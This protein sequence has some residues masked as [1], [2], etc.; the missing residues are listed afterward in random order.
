[1]IILLSFLIFTVD[2]WDGG[3]KYDNEPVIYHGIRGKTLT[4]KIFFKDVVKDAILPYAFCKSEFP[5]ILS[6]ENHC[7]VEY[8]DQ[9]ADCLV[10]LL[11]DILYTEKVDETRCEL[12][13][14]DELRGKILVKAKKRRTHEQEGTYDVHVFCSD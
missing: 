1:M 9:M 3:P 4:S 11:G 8:Q 7:S 10:N 5:L 12:P 13:S 2:C 14:P 6:I